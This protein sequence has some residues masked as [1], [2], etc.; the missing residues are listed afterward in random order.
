MLVTLFILF[1]HILNQMRFVMI[2]I[3][4]LTLRAF[5]SF[6]NLKFLSRF[7]FQKECFGVFSSYLVKLYVGSDARIR[8]ESIK[9]LNRQKQDSVKILK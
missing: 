2:L 9:I 4:D 5:W 7:N 8:S 6:M 3:N 1:I